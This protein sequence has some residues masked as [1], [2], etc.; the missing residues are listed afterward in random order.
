MIRKLEQD[1]D[2]F[3]KKIKKEILL[4]PYNNYPLNIFGYL[5]N[6]DKLSYAYMNYK[7]DKLNIFEFLLSYIKNFF[8]IFYFNTY[9]LYKKKIL[10]KS[11]K[12][13]ITWGKKSDFDTKGDFMDRYCG[14]NSK[15]QQKT[16]FVVQYEEDELPKKIAENIL[17]FKKN[18]KKK[19][20]FYLILQILKESKSVFNFINSLSHSSLYSVIFYKKINHQ[21]KNIDIKEI[22]IPFE[23]QLFQRYFIKKKKNKD[24]KIIGLIHTFL[25][26]IP[27]N[28]FYNK[29]FSPD[30]LIVSSLSQKKCLTKYMNWREKSIIIN[31]SKRFFR[32]IKPSMARTIFLPYKIN[33]RNTLESLFKNFLILNK[34]TS[35]LNFKI[36][37]HP[38][39]IFNDKHLKFKDKIFKIINKNQE[40]IVVKNKSNI[41]IFFEYT[42]AIIEA[43]ERGVR[44]VQICSNPLLQAYTPYFW[45]GI[46]IKK[47]AK[48]IFEYKITK[49][50]T[51]IK[52][53]S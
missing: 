7:L 15:M 5:S 38:I 1:Q 28:I 27:F 52:M 45:K 34:N 2:N 11:K 19:I 40:K 49:K 12:L 17:I 21:L 46:I 23:G 33:C 30:K 37:I 8:S 41:S 32:S 10:K 22:V 47:I 31:N 4:N 50:N 13:I 48:N 20:P 18:K 42:S 25:Q 26:P 44:V 29:F 24:T 36:K 3:Y 14:I 9:T 6:S 35:F 43:L 16:I 51:L 39:K 53:K